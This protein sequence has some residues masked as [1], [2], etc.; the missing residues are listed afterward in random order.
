MAQQT[1]AK[2]PDETRK[3]IASI[4]ERTGMTITQVLIVA[5]DRMSREVEPRDE[6]A[7]NIDRSVWIDLSKVSRDR[8]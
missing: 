6:G 5:I 2:L 1:N 3:Q 4:C 8:S 7:S